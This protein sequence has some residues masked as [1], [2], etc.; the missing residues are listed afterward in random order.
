MT[1]L[2]FNV[3]F[4]GI[5]CYSLYII[6]YYDRSYW[7]P[8]C[9]MLKLFADPFFHLFQQFI[10]WKFFLWGWITVA[11]EKKRHR[12]STYIYI[13][14]A[15]EF[16]EKLT[17]MFYII[18]LACHNFWGLLILMTHE[19]FAFWRKCVS[20]FFIF[21]HMV[22]FEGKELPDIQRHWTTCGGNGVDFSAHFV[23]L[24]GYYGWS[25]VI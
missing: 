18:L 24:D 7:F 21:C 12:V 10:Q 5:I 11:K 22:H 15:A 20:Y 17:T 23:R 16:E 6:C 4:F 1:Y 8:K 14:G 3:F 9:E 19:K 2:N 25:F 13:K